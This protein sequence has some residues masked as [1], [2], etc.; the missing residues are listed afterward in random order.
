MIANFY[1][2]KS[3]SRYI[4]KDIDLISYNNISDIPISII[5]P[6]SVVYPTFKLS[7]GLMG[8]NANYMYVNDLHRYYFIK[9]WSM[10]NGYIKI[11]CECDV[12]MS[13]KTYIK[14]RSVV[15]KRQENK[16]NLYLDD[17]KYKVQNRTATMTKKFPN[18]FGSAKHLVM[19]VVG[20]AQ[21]ES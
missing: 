8:Q 14:N 9:N 6:S 7:S 21:E 3:D 18:G 20:K 15:V 13:F 19:G 2:N 5:E 4:D 10:E 11:E 12:L 16:F 1:E 17:Q